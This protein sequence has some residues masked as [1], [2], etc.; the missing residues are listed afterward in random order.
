VRERFRRKWIMTLADS[1]GQ[2]EAE[3]KG[4]LQDRKKSIVLGRTPRAYTQ[5]SEKK[6]SQARPTTS[7]EKTMQEG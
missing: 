2:I 7:G 3:E 5:R 4:S 1:R 6:S